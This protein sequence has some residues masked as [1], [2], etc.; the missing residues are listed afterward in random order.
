MISVYI[1]DDHPIL[2]Q[3]LAGLLSVAEDISIIG[4][5][6][7]G[8]AAIDEVMDLRPDV[9]LM[10]LRL[11][12]ISGA[13]TT[14]KILD[15]AR[16]TGQGWVPRIVILTTYEDDNSITVAIEAGATGYMLKSATPDEIMAAI[17]SA[18]E[19]HTVLAPSVASAL[20]R[21]MKKSTETRTL[22]SREQDVLR[23]MAQ[24]LS[25]AEIASTLFVEPSTVKTHIEHIFTKL[26]VSRRAQAVARAH[27]M[28]VV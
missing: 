17:R 5:A 7:S 6:A 2:R 18:S 25:N 13:E 21:H 19:G 4:D 1:V 16:L 3:G 9:I 8:E 22:S 26:G 24:G 11:P 20:V 14:E 27:E 23:L 15:Q 28:G 12:G 10:D